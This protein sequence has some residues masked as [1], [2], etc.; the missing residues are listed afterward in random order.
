MAKIGII[1]AMEEEIFAL[2]EKL[3][4]KEVRSI[5][6]LDFFAGVLQNKEVVLVRCGIGKVN[7]AI[8]TQLLIDCFQVDSII[9]T[10]VAGALAD[11][12]D[13]GDIIISSDAIEHDMDASVFGYDLGVIPR[14]EESVFKSDKRLVH[15]AQKASEVLSVNTKV[16]T[17]RIVSGDQFI[18]SQ[19]KKKQ[20]TKIFNGACTEMEG[21]AIAH[22]CY[23]NKVPFVIIRSISDKADDS[24]EV[25]FSEFSRAAATNSCK[26]IEKMLELM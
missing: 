20:L 8:C 22:A 7:A 26:M 2:K 16:Y 5:A 6:S 9:N 21:A 25:N 14:M 23:L 11:N 12:L 19:E 10:G 13:I 24:A 4:V 3:K 17:D 1:G 18:S 15:I